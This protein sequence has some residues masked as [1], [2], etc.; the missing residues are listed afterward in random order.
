LVE[1][2][3]AARPD[4]VVHSHYGPTETT[5]AVM[6][7]DVSEVP[8]QRRHGFVPLGRPLANV[9]AHVVDAAGQPVP[10]GL[11]G[12]LVI[13]G[14]GVARGYRGGN[15]SATAFRPDPVTGDGRCYRTGDRVRIRAD[16]TVEFHGRVDDQVKIRGYRV[17]PGEVVAALRRL[18]GVAEAVVLPDIELM[19][20]AAVGG[21]LLAWLVP[22]AG[23]VIEAAEILAAVREH[24]PEHMVPSAAMVVDALPLGPNGRCSVSPRRRGRNGTSRLSGG[25]CSAAPRWGAT[26]TSSRS[27]VTR[28]G[29]SWPRERSAVAFVPSTCSPI[30]RYGPLPSCST[31]R[32]T[33]TRVTRRRAGCCTA[34]PAHRSGRP[35]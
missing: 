33:R 11:T 22:R 31:V 13:G 30:R 7:C 32:P 3:E 1:Q 26:T 17:E 23:Q 5:V 10:V 15:D 16:G 28:S 14:P 27:A 12:E 6:A 19:T 25:T 24:V 4:L 9:V 20:D 29:P 35:R 18:P 34:S 8:P 21:R 2:V